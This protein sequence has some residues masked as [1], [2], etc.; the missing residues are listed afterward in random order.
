MHVM[1]KFEMTFSF[2]CCNITHLFGI[3]DF[4]NEVRDI[5][6]NRNSIIKSPYESSLEIF[7]NE[8]NFKKK[9]GK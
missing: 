7:A 9:L 1:I 3:F 8:V 4:K 6:T 2:Q 5:F